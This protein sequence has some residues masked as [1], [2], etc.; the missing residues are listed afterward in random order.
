M[1]DISNQMLEDFA[2][3]MEGEVRGEATSTRPPRTAYACEHFVSGG[4]SL[5]S[6]RSC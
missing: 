3:D 2:F 4:L 5:P 1:I 6:A